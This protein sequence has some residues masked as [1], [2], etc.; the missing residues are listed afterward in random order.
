[1]GKLWIVAIAIVAA[2]ASA[3]AQ[4]T[5]TEKCQ[6]IRSGD[7]IIGWA[8][9]SGGTKKWCEATVTQCSITSCGYT[10]IT[11]S[12]GRLLALM[13]ECDVSGSAESSSSELLAIL[14]S[15]RDAVQLTR[16]IARARVA[17]NERAATLD[18]P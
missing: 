2:S 6:A 4:G 3:R 12:D 9:L 18:T 15:G 13:K 10:S 14:D 8:C 11:T 16:S 7:Q 17:E 1:M 5:C